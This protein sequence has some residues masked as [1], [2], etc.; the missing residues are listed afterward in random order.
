MTLQLVITS[1]SFEMV[2]WVIIK[3]IQIDVDTILM[4]VQ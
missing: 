4:P 2:V 3:Q 1:F